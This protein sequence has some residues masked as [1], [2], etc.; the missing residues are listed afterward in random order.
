MPVLDGL[1]TI[2][3]V[4]EWQKQGYLN[5]HLPVIAVTANAR[6][7]QKDELIQSGVDDVVTKPFRIPDLVEQMEILLQRFDA[8]GG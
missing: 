2:K 8:E 6:S 3:K 7:E 4:R 1:E 5:G